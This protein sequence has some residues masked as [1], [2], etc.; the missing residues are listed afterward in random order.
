MG[1]WSLLKKYLEGG[2]CSGVTAGIRSR[3]SAHSYERE[4]AYHEY[5]PYFLP[6]LLILRI[7]GMKTTYNN[8]V[9]F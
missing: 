8:S 7:T 4:N 6:F 1:A 3:L 2:I 9:R 5:R